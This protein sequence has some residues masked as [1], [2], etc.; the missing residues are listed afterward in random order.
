MI[1]IESLYNKI[2]KKKRRIYRISKK[3]YSNKT[4]DNTERPTHPFQHIV[5]KIVCVKLLFSNIFLE[6][7]LLE[8][9]KKMKQQNKLDFTEQI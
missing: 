7:L 6:I 2:D 9:K 3:N 8:K 5:T 1:Y 4:Y